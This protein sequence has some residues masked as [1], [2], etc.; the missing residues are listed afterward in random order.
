ML[1]RAGSKGHWTTDTVKKAGKDTRTT[2]LARAQAV[3]NPH[4]NLAAKAQMKGR[5]GTR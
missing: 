2:G 4:A 5:M 3:A 1:Q